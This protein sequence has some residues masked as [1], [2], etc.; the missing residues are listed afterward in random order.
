MGSAPKLT[1][2]APAE[3]AVADR[4]WGPP[5][6]TRVTLS[7]SPGRKCVPETTTSVPVNFSVAAGLHDAVTVR[8]KV[9]LVPAA[10]TARSV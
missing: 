10:P 1:L 9:T 5:P 8:L 6:S 7:F 4:L 2:K 3:L